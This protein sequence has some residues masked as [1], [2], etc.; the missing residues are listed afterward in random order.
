MTG[1]SRER[2]P[3]LE[4]APRGRGSRLPAVEGV[5]QFGCDTLKGVVFEPL[6]VVARAAQATGASRLCSRPEEFFEV[7]G[8]KRPERL[9][10]CRQGGHERP[11]WRTIR[12][13]ECRDH[14]SHFLRVG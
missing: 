11:V 13:K 6:H 9:N 4:L 3:P 14:R 7:L 2:P 10:M 8:R 1:I 5:S 12:A